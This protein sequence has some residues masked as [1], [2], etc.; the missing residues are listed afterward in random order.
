[1]RYRTNL[2]KEKKE[3]KEKKETERA[4]D[5]EWGGVHALFSHFHP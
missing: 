3:K 2:V 1:M 5:P 4:G